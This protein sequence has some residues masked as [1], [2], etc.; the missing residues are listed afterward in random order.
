MAIKALSFTVYEMRHFNDTWY[1]QSTMSELF[2]APLPPSWRLTYPSFFHFSACSKPDEGL[3]D[4]YYIHLFVTACSFG[5]QN[6]CW[7]F[8][9]RDILS[10]H[11]DQRPN[12][13]TL[14]SGLCQYPLLTM[15][16][17]G[18]PIADL[19]ATVLSYLQSVLFTSRKADQII[20]ICVVF[21][22]L[23]AAKAVYNILIY[24]KISPLRHLPTPVQTPLW[25]RLLK[26][27]TPWLFEKWMKEVPNDGLI[28]YFGILNR[29]RL[30]LTTSS[31]ARD[32]LVTNPY[33]FHK[34]R[35]QKI[36]LEPVLG[37]D[38]VCVEGDVHKFHRKHMSP[39]FA[40]KAIRACQPV[41]WQKTQEVVG[42]FSSKIN[43]LGVT[44]HKA[45][46]PDQASGVVEVHEPLSRAAL[47]IIGIAGCGFDLGHQTK[48]EDQNK[49][50]GNYRK[51]FGVSTSN[52]LRCLMAHFFPAWVVNSIPIQRNRDVALVRSVATMLASN[53]LAAK[54]RCSRLSNQGPDL[55]DKIMGSGAFSD[56][57]LIDQVKTLMAAGHDTTSSTV[58]SAAA[59]LSQPRFKHIQD[60]VRAEIRASLPSISSPSLASS[61]EIENL[62]YLNAVRNE[63]F[64]LYA[65]LS[66][67]FRRSVVDT[68]ICN[69]RVPKGTDI[70]L[71]PWAMHRS[72]ELW[73]PDAEEFDPNR[74]LND[75]SGRGGAR[76]P[77]CLLTFGAGPRVCIAERFARIEISTLLAGIFGRFRVEK[78][79]GEPEPRLS[80]QLTLTR[81]GGVKVRMTPLEGW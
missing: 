57:E 26:E 73:G 60:K 78:V 77:Y 70:I 69:H 71:C 36:H 7:S 2:Q 48:D 20:A 24:H 25:R 67:F 37:R 46:E 61:T 53:I 51:A 10:C 9:V 39:A 79:A 64:R 38:L 50:V 55:L 33:H 19:A 14:K 65:P 13:S 58:A 27:P 72:S 66:W 44:A 18:Y 42:L 6:F 47:D 31:A 29:E 30:L 41:F 68:T 62:P 56:E 17:P 22:L 54:R 16:S 23:F 74:W 49:V 81:I 43:R 11:R 40:T 15:L 8:Q 80:H 75:P 21:S 34:Q 76:D 63:L 1:P 45:T 32:V 52:R 5:L 3:A 28:R 4:S 12:P 35:A 59:I